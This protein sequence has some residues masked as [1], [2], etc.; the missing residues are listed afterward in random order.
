MK[1]ILQKAPTF[2]DSSIAVLEFQ[3]P[4]FY[5]PWHFHPEYEL[6]LVLESDG[7]RF[8]GDNIKN[9]GPG[10]IVLIGPNLPHWYRSDAS[11]YENNTK[12]RACSIVIFFTEKTMGDLFLSCPEAIHIKKILQQSVLGLEIYGDTRKQIS[13]M[14][15]KI[16]DSKGMDKLL[17]FLSILNILAKSNEFFSLSVAGPGNIR[18]K[19]S[20]II[21]RVYE[22]IMKNFKKQISLNEIST[23]VNLSTSTFCRFFKKR[24]RKTFKYLLNEIRI[25][26]AC[27]LLIEK[28]SSV[29]EISFASGFNNISYFNRQFKAI[30]KT[31]PYLYKKEYFNRNN[32]KKTNLYPALTFRNK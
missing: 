12:L 22:Y 18:E 26:H 29:G 19:D 10:D 8:I 28:D 7:K 23:L 1:P 16:L 14:M 6:V 11:Y 3:A 25:G 5:V 30:K 13:Q 21:N 32:S 31:T 9:F 4:Y 2:L 15:M 17:Y 27:K 20:E 24:T